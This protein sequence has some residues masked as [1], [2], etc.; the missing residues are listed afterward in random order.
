MT[1]LFIVGGNGVL[2]SAAAK[3][4]LGKG[5]KVSVL[6]RDRSKASVL[7]K[8]GANVLTGD[9]TIPADVK[10]IF[11]GADVVLTAVHSL[12]GR[13]KNKSQNVDDTGHRRL[14]DEAKSSGVK[15]FIYTSAVNVSENHPIDFYRTKYK[16]EQYLKN[17][18]LKHTILRLPALMEW[19]AY[20]LL[21]KSIVDKGKVTIFGN[22]T[23]PLNFIAV[24]DIVAALELMVLNEEYYNQTVILGGPDNL[25]RNEVAERFGEVLKIKPK[26]GHVPTG[27]LKVFAVLMQPLHPG[28]SRI[29]KYTL[30]TDQSNEVLDEKFTIGRFGLKPTTMNEF[31]HSVTGNQTA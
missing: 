2:G 31:I 12:L 29:M 28:F 21:G 11:K 10:N 9:I 25:S 19:H 27:A 24:R 16:I 14:I 6:V 30:H 3:L 18:G 15:Q 1:H 13:G 20:N 22:G 23:N 8:A 7:E 5:Y 17:S 26:I 4:F